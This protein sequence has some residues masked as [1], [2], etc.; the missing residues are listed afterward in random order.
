MAGGVGEHRLEALARQALALAASLRLLTRSAQPL[1]EVVAS[2]LEFGDVDET[3]GLGGGEALGLACPGRLGVG[4][5]APLEPRDLV[6][7]R[8]ASR[9]LIAPLDGRHVVAL[10]KAGD[11]CSALPECRRRLEHLEVGRLGIAAGVQD[12]GQVTGIDA[13]GAGCIGCSGSEFLD[14]RCGGAG[15]DKGPLALTRRHKSLRLEA[16]VD[17]AGRVRVHSHPGGKL[18]DARQAVPGSQAAADDQRPQ[19]PGE[20]DA[21]RKVVP[22]IQLHFS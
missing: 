17:G 15:G 9:G 4:G 14:R 3:P 16:P 19:A 2:A 11:S 6:A 20:V 18:A 13:G 7:Q 8:A 5:E 1:D 12:A 10:L 22:T 21:D